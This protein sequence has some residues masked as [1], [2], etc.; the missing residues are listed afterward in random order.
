MGLRRRQVRRVLVGERR[1]HM[2]RHATAEADPATKALLARIGKKCPA[3]GKIVEKTEGCHIMMCGTNAHGKVADA[4]RNGGCAFIFDWNTMKEC[5]D[6][7][8]YHDI[9]GVWQRGKGPRTD[10]QILLS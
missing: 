5:E 7:H 10:R 3:C 8:G 9:N 4:L 1:K 6:G 2:C